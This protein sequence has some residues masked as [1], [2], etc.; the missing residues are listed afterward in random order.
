MVND[1][2]F[3]S[4][5]QKTFVFMNFAKMTGLAYNDLHFRCITHIAHLG[6]PE[7]YCS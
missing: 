6:K 4:E 7:H 1:A 2:N 3:A 5:S